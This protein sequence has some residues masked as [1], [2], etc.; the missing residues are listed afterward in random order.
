ML[1]EVFSKETTDMSV[2]QLAK[3]LFFEGW[4]VMRVTISSERL[5]SN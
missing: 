1:T 4:D 3:L 5:D 2:L